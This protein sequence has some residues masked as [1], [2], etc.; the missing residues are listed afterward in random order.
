MEYRKFGNQYVV[1]LDKGEEV[2][3]EITKVCE[4]AGIRTGVISGLG[5]AKVIESGFFD[6]YGQRFQKEHCEGI[7]EVTSLVGNITRKDGDVYLH[8]HIT[9]SDDSGRVYGGHLAKCVVSAT[10]EIFITEI[11]GDVQRRFDDAI[12]LN[13][14]E[15]GDNC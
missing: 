5:A 11:D 1:R 4:E 3:E 10:G 8:I 6:P 12:G 13:L 7:F 9:Y 15:F 14:L 2:V